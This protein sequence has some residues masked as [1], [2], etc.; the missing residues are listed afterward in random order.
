MEPQVKPMVVGGAN[1]RDKV[2]CVQG[3]IPEH[4]V[5]GGPE[6]R[7]EG[8]AGRVLRSLSEEN[9]APTLVSS[10]LEGRSSRH[11]GGEGCSGDISAS[12]PGRAGTCCIVGRGELPEARR[13]FEGDCRAFSPAAVE[14]I[15]S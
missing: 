14:G 3:E 4:L 13:S 8:L 7:L 11:L 10:V 15:P 1:S 12:L 6:V 5:H 2:Y 9:L